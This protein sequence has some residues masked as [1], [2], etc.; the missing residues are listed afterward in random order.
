MPTSVDDLTNSGCGF[1]I[2]T[3]EFGHLYYTEL[4][5]KGYYDTSG[6]YQ[7]GWGLVNDGPFQHLQSTSY[8]SG[9][10]AS[11]IPN[12]AWYFDTYFGFQYVDG[13]D[14]GHEASPLLPGMAVRSGQVSEAAPVP[15]PS[16]L[17]LL[18]VG[19]LGLARWRL[20]KRG[21]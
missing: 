5:N 19:F 21:R 4:G 11:G 17:L 12:Y 9:T 16:T 7:P 2:A 13:E 3:S 18:S 10:E 15:E 8:W 20:H 1:N 6:N 14:V